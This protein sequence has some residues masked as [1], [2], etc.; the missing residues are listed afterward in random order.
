[1]II[2]FILLA[3]FLYVS[4]S[5]VS[6]ESKLDYNTPEGLMNSVKIYGGWLAHGF[7]NMKVLTGKAI[8]MDWKSTNGTFF[9]KN[10]TNKK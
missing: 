7:Q 4:I 6:K 3:L 2:L 8:N 1:M 5:I 10:I 9:Y